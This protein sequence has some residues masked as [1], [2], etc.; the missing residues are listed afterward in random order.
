MTADR[1]APVT[2]QLQLRELGVQPLQRCRLGDQHIH[3]HVI[4]DRHLIEQPAELGLLQRETL[5]QPV[6]LGEHQGDIMA[7]SVAVTSGL[8]KGDRV[9]TA[10]VHTLSDGQPVKLAE[11]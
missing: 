10:G 11:Q 9:I 8:A 5:G 1:S 6:T 3:L 7:A 4:A 2:E